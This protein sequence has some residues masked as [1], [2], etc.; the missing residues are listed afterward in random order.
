MQKN[1]KEILLNDLLL[2]GG[3]N[4]PKGSLKKLA[5]KYNVPEGTVRR[6]KSEHFKKNSTNVQNKKRTNERPIK[7][8]DVAIKLDILAGKEKDEIMQKYEISNT[9]LWRKEKSIRY[10]T[11]EKTEKIL[12][13]ATDYAYPDGAGMLKKVK[14]KKRNLMVNIIS[15]AESNLLDKNKQEAIGKA[16][17]N[18]SK[19]E[20]EIM[21]DLGLVSLYKQLEIDRELAEEKLQSDKLEIEKL[22]QGIEED[23][24]L[25]IKIIGV[26]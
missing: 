10:L 2:L 20:L 23:K 24:K 3:L 25:E 26:D 22:K 14:G 8:K 18:I 4:A 19:I 7:S 1:I 16:L 13:E 15:N 6:W 9:T 11:N 12:K 5:D 21:K 17:S